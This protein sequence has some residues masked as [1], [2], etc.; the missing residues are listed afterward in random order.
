MMAAIG[1]NR[2]TERIV[3]ETD[4]H[5]ITGEITLPQEGYQSRFS[6]SINRGDVAF[7]P[8][9][10]AEITPLGGGETERRDFI[11][12]AKSYVRLAYPVSG[13]A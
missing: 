10:N 13:E 1:G 4:R 3:F 5:L 11:V 7:M 2:R 6:D 12:L 8:I 9:V